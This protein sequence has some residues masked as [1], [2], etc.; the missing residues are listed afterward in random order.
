MALNIDLPISADLSTDRWLK[1][2]NIILDVDGKTPMSEGGWDELFAASGVEHPICGVIETPDACVIFTETITGNYPGAI[3]RYKN[4]TLTKIIQ[5]YKFPFNRNN[6]ITGSY[7]TNSKGDLIVTWTDGVT[8]ICILNLDDLPFALNSSKEII[9]ETDDLYSLV[10]IFPYVKY[11]IYNTNINSGGNLPRGTYWYF[12][13]YGLGNGIFYNWSSISSFPVYISKIHYAAYNGGMWI[14]KY[15]TE[16]ELENT[17]TANSGMS[18]DLTIGNIDTKYKTLKIGILYMNESGVLTGYETEEFSITPTTTS[19]SYTH[20]SNKNEIGHTEIITDYLFFRGAEALDNYQG[21]IIVGNIF[22]YDTVNIQKYVNNWKVRQVFGEANPYN[23]LTNNGY[24][25]IKTFMPGDVYSFN[26]HLIH[27][28]GFITKG[29][30]IPHIYNPTDHLSSWDTLRDESYV[31][32]KEYKIMTTRYTETAGFNMWANENEVYPDIESSEI[33]NSDGISTGNLAGESV[34]Y[35]K[36]AYPDEYS[37]RIEHGDTPWTK[38]GIKVIDVYLPPSIAIDY[39]GYFISHV[40]REPT[41]MY[42]TSM[43]YD[44]YSAYSTHRFF[45]I[46]TLAN[47]PNIQGYIRF[48]MSHIDGTIVGHMNDLNLYPNRSTYLHDPHGTQTRFYPI[49]DFKYIP[50]NSSVSNPKNEYREETLYIKIGHSYTATTTNKAHYIATL[51]QSLPT[52]LYLDKTKP[53]SRCSSIYNLSANKTNEEYHGDAFLQL[54]FI[55][56]ADHATASTPVTPATSNISFGFV[57]YSNI[58]SSRS[59]PVGIATE[60][61]F[62]TVPEWGTPNV[63]QYYYNMTYNKLNSMKPLFKFDPIIP[64]DDVS[65]KLIL[66]S[67][68]SPAD[69]LIVNWR[70]FPVDRSYTVANATSG[71]V[72]ILTLKDKLFIFT[73]TEVLIATLHDTLNTIGQSLRTVQS[74]LFDYKPELLL[75][76]NS[77]SLGISHKLHVTKYT[78]GVVWFTLHSGNIYHISDSL[79]NITEGRIKSLIDNLLNKTIGTVKLKNYANPFNG[80]FHLKVDEDRKRLLFTINVNDSNQLFPTTLSYNFVKKEWVAAH[81]YAASYISFNKQGLHLIGDTASRAK[82]Y[83]YNPLKNPSFRGTLESFID[84]LFVPTNIANFYYESLIIRQEIVSLGEI[85]QTQPT[86]KIRAIAIYNSHQFS[87]EIILTEKEKITDRD[88]NYDNVEGLV[89]FNKFLDNIKSITDPITL[90]NWSLNSSNVN[91]L[92]SAAPVDTYSTYILNIPSGGSV[93]YNG[94]TYKDNGKLLRTTHN[95]S[96]TLS[97]GSTLS[98]INGVAKRQFISPYIIVRVSWNSSTHI[99]KILEIKVNTSYEKIPKDK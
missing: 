71:I 77:G 29:F 76:S 45:D 67:E 70:L 47:K 24:Q 40:L 19:I 81:D 80:G 26:A 55:S 82:I 79:E 65:E 13:S 39:Q 16:A 73:S 28:R 87:G 66:R 5:S 97:G 93:I 64:I 31:V 51:I 34:K 56:R 52:D 63:L 92:T 48:M 90:P 3:Y 25:W 61:W 69:S 85:D 98:K 21:D 2:K 43:G 36:F 10:N 60:S 94:I 53:C 14:E 89:I 18:V 37:N 49:V 95:T 57:N 91:G 23:A 68:E 74:S 8:E 32:A 83:K 44:T 7:T 30:N 96:I 62:E 42:G 84:Y 27:K 75:D 6:P 50:A 58:Q 38:L 46:D 12:I 11:P 4:E 72:E 20:T 88:G 17:I 22:N 35:H 9:G 59:I 99:V 54:E 78:S 41:I 33:G 86:N 1:A 15:V